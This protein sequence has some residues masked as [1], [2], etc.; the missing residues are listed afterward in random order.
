MSK[1]ILSPSLSSSTPP[2]F[3]EDRTQTEP[4]LECPLIDHNT[5]Q[6]VTEP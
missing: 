1:S 3:E 4:Q 5:K 6:N 2:N